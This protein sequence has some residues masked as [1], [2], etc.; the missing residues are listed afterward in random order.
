MPYKLELLQSGYIYSAVIVLCRVSSGFHAR[1]IGKLQ[2]S[3]FDEFSFILCSTVQHISSCT[4]IGA[5]HAIY[6]LH[7]PVFLSPLCV[8]VHCSIG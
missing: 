6:T 2:P 3:R 8:T 4:N 1:D 7:D 5:A